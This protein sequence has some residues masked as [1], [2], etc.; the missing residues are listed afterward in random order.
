MLCRDATGAAAGTTFPQAR[1]QGARLSD[2]TP[3]E[4]GGGPQGP[5]GS[6]E[7]AASA[8]FLIC[9]MSGSFLGDK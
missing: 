2:T 5:R 4:M 1:S 7:G 6:A 3:P 8:P 9:T